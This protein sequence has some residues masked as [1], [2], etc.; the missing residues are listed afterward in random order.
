MEILEIDDSSLRSSLYQVV[1]MKLPNVTKLKITDDSNSKNLVFP[2]IVLNLQ[3]FFNQITELI[4]PRYF[5]FPEQEQESS[6]NP[7]LTVYFFR[8][9]F[10]SLQSLTISDRCLPAKTWSS[11]NHDRFAQFC[12][13]N[14]N[15]KHINVDHSEIGTLEGDSL[16]DWYNELH[17]TTGIETCSIFMSKRKKNPLELIGWREAAMDE[18]ELFGRLLTDDENRFFI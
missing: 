18:T 3:F 2:A 16:I 17:G 4:L 7:A 6:L 8:I 14:T 15:L 11:K 9:K 10:E 13:L 1:F 12:T 5:V